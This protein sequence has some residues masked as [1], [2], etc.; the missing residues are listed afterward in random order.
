M[1]NLGRCNQGTYKDEIKKVPEEN[2]GALC[3]TS[4]GHGYSASIIEL[5]VMEIFHFG[6]IFRA[7]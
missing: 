6:H 3:G 2:N 4:P 1:K 7:D 5:P